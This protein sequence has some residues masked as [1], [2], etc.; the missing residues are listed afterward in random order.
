MQSKKTC[1]KTQSKKNYSLNE[2]KICRELKLLVLLQ[3]LLVKQKDK[4]HT[5]TKANMCNIQQY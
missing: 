5:H 4:S 1:R 3:V 2:K